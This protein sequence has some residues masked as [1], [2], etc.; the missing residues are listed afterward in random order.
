MNYS[1]I[2]VHRGIMHQILPKEGIQEHGTAV[3]DQNLYNVENAVKKIIRSRIVQA[4]GRDARAFELEIAN[5]SPGMYF[6]LANGIKALTDDQFIAA[7][8]NIATLLAKAQRRK[9]IPKSYMILLDCTDKT[10]NKGIYIVIKAELHEALTKKVDRDRAFFEVL[11][12]IFL[13]PSTR[14]YKIGILYEESNPGKPYPNNEYGC[15]L[16]DE[17]FQLDGSKPAEY[18]YKDFLGFSVDNNSKIQTRKLYQE[19]Y[20]FIIQHAPTGEK[21]KLINALRT[22]FDANV[23]ES[24]SPK[25]FAKKYFKTVQ[26]RDHYSREVRWPNFH[27]QKN[28]L[29]LEINYGSEKAKR[30]PTQV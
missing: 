10:A 9:D 3:F 18:F 24:I 17:Q 14:L 12:E 1:T 21:N 20:E 5:T 16:F 2:D 23:Q 27:G 6:D 25:E 4:A 7:S 8:Q 26:L 29:N 30:E 13:S 19:T 22:E 15:F 28:L 11:S